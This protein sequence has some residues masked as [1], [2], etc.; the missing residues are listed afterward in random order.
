MMNLPLILACPGGPALIFILLVPI[1]GLVP[2]ILSYLILT[3][4]PL[5]ALGL[6]LSLC[7]QSATP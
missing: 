4:V 7:R 5:G 1:Y 2:G 3:P 6:W